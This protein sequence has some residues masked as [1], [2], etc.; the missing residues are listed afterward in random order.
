ML[1]NVRKDKNLFVD[2]DNH[3]DNNYTF[4]VLAL[5]FKIFSDETNTSLLILLTFLALITTFVQ[6]LS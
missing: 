1:T 5:R 4:V 2:K 6:N 3:F